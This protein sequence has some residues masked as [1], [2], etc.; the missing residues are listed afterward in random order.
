MHNNVLKL[1]YNKFVKIIFFS[2]NKACLIF[3]CGRLLCKLSLISNFNS[4]FSS[5]LSLIVQ[6]HIIIKSF[7]LI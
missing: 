4:L 1:K 5:L 3:Y 2:N 6:V 7:G